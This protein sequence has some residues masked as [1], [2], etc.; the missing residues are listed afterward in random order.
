LSPDRG[1]LVECLLN[2]FHMKQFVV[3]VVLPYSQY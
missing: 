1:K 3:C 2:A